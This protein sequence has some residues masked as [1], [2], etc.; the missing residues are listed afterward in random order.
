MKFCKICGEKISSYSSG[1]HYCSEECKAKDFPWRYIEELTYDEEQILIGSLLGDGNLSIGKF[2]KYPTYRED[3]KKEHRDYLEYKNEIL[4]RFNSKVSMRTRQNKARKIQFDIYNLTTATIPVFQSYY[5]KFYPNGKKILPV[6]LLEKVDPLG[7]SIWF[8]DDGSYG[9]LYKF[10]QISTH[11]FTF[12]EHEIMV[13]WFKRKFNISPRISKDGV[14]YRL[15]FTK[16]DTV[17]FIEIVR[18]YIHPI[19][20]YKLGEKETNIKLV[21]QKMS[22]ST[23]IFFMNEREIIY[24]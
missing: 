19:M 21:D 11:C 6:D 17:K 9:Q 12:K 14:H 20:K 23:D 10:I 7:L 3:K 24:G 16:P 4:H 2:G 18:P 1:R 15:Q 5:E 22:D 8:C 13:D